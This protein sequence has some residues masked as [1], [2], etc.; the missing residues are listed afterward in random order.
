MQQF[1]LIGG[2]MLFIVSMFGIILTDVYRYSL[3]LSHNT[4]EKLFV[5]GIIGLILGV[6]SMFFC[7]GLTIGG[8]ISTIVNIVVLWLLVYY[9]RCIYSCEWPRRISILLVIITGFVFFGCFVEDTQFFIGN[10]VL[11]VQMLFFPIMYI[12]EGRDC[13]PGDII[14]ITMGI[15]HLLFCIVCI[16]S[17]PCDCCRCC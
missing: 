17:G 2:T 4:H 1:V 10:M 6:G 13:E 16:N 11:V 3:Q 8:F 15:I 14:L 9:Y 7:G 12:I 5:G